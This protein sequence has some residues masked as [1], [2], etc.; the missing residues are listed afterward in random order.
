MYTVIHLYR[1]KKENVEIFLDIRDRINEI[2]LLNGTLEK[3]IYHV[4]NLDGHHGCNGLHSLISVN[5][6]EQIFFGQSIYRN[7]SHY[8]DVKNQV[9]HNDEMNQLLEELKKNID[10]SE[11]ITASFTTR[12]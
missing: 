10:L 1:V 12:V 9:N 4:D 7:K 2:H 6:N 8:E 5:N 11:T 3:T